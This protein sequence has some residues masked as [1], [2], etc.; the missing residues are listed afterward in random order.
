M[1]HQ[2]PHHALYTLGT[3]RPKIEPL[4]SVINGFV[5][6]NM[7]KHSVCLYLAEDSPS[8]VEPDSEGLTDLRLRV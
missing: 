5:P 3:V 6:A 2:R 8:A 7:V 4:K 1:S